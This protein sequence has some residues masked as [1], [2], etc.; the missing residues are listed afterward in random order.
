MLGEGFGGFLVVDRWSAYPWKPRGMRLVCWA[1]LVR[2][3]RSFVE[4][5]GASAR[6]GEKLLAQARLMFRCWHRIRD[7]TLTRVTFRRQKGGLLLAA[8]RPG[9]RRCEG[10]RPGR[11]LTC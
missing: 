3:F 10:G 4:R 11:G 2:D 8:R 9:R 7:G 5:G 1:H 6:M